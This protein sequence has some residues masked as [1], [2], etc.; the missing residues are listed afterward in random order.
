[1]QSVTEA[2]QGFSDIATL[3]PAGLPFREGSG[4]RYDTSLSTALRDLYVTNDSTINFKLGLEFEPRY[5]R[6]VEQFPRFPFAYVALAESMRYRG[7]PQ[8]PRFPFAYVALAESMRYRGDPLWREY[9]KKAV[10][11]L[12]K[13]TTI[14]GH[15]RT[16]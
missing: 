15:D 11:I 4:I 7:D 1:L 5:K 12:E 8:F 10:S 14:E 13:T 6:I 3:N 9:A 2:I 16:L